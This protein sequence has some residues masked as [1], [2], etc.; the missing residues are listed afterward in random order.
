[1]RTAV[2]AALLAVAPTGEELT[3]VGDDN[4]ECGRHNL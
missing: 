3:D 2:M 4:P 1:M